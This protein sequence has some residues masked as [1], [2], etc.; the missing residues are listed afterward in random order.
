MR[1]AVG[2]HQTV[3]A[4]LAIVRFVAKI[5]AVGPANAAVVEG[6][7]DGLIRPVPDKPALQARI[8]A[9]CLPVISK[10][11]EAITH[12]MGVFAED[13]RALFPRQTDPLFDSPFRHRRNRLVAVNAGVHR[14]DNIGGGAVGAAAFVLY[15][16]GGI[17]AF[18]PVIHRFMVA[19]AAGL[20]PQ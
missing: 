5:T 3:H 9:K 14:A 12:R 18:Q 13:Q 19:A 15:R 4:E 6:F 1:A 2:E 11:A 17:V 8:V 10:V 16:A 7:T 20:I